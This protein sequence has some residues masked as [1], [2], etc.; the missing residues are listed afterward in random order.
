LSI[1]VPK[2]E[3]CHFWQTNCFENVNLYDAIFHSFYLPIHL[4]GTIRDGNI[5]DLI[6]I[7]TPAKK[8]DDCHHPG[9]SQTKQSDN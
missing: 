2:D 9:H 8:P 3:V 4:S 5:L 6:V 7:A 1:R